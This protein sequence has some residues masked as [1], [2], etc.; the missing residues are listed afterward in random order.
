MYFFHLYVP[1]RLPEPMWR[2]LPKGLQNKIIKDIP[3]AHRV[4][5]DNLA[6][7]YNRYK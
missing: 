6:N 5:P 4:Y 2:E 7:D 1:E 3:R